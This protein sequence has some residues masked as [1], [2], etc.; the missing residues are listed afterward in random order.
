MRILGIRRWLLW[1][2]LLFGVG[3]LSIGI[4]ATWKNQ[5]RMEQQRETPTSQ[6]I[7]VAR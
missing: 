4:C 6:M 5:H 7:S 2:Y 1:T 3:A